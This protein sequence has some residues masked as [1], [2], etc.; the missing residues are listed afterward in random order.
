MPRTMSALKMLF[1][2]AQL[3]ALLLSPRRCLLGSSTRAN[4]RMEIVVSVMAPLQVC[5]DSLHV[6]VRH[7]GRD[8]V[9]RSGGQ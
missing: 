2:E 3:P 9:F 7:E 1:L 5:E 6:L 8:L 4:N